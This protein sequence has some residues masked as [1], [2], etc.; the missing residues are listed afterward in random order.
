MTDPSNDIMPIFNPHWF[1][2]NGHV[3]SILASSHLLIRPRSE[4]QK[5]ADPMIFSTS[6]G[7][8][9]LARHTRHPHAIGLMILLHG[10]EGSDTSAY[11]LSAG[12]HFYRSGFSVIR[13]NLRDH[14]ESHHLNEGMFHGAL[15]NETFDAIHQAAKTA[16][17]LPVYLLGFSLGANFALRCAI[18]HAT[19]PIENLK[20]VFAVSP[21]L[22]PYKTT[23]AID[24]APAI[25][26]KYFLKK[27]KRSLRI[28]QRLFPDTYAFNALLESQT[29]LDLTEKMMKYFPQF[30]SYR[31]YFKLY[32]LTKDS[33]ADLNLPVSLFIAKDD[34]VIPAD[35]FD[36]LTE[37]DLFR[38]NRSEYGGHCG[39]IDLFPQRRWYNE[40]IRNIIVSPS[41]DTK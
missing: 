17:D 29:C 4:F 12:S 2:R 11:M 15:I 28:K 26:R 27:W 23:L 6:E 35:D 8:K 37:N 33:F 22:D 38:I 24:S 40:I 20:Q 21:P 34:P 3:Q 31:D 10:W 19:T 30:P 7:S 36:S 32:T 16:P 39:F 1:L 25:Y 5:T 14:G 18:R 9:L 41:M 13:L